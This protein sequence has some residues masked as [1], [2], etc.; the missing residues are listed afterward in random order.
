M[1]ITKK[2]WPNPGKIILQ[3]AK[4]QNSDANASHK[5]QGMFSL[6]IADIQV[7]DLWSI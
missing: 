7:W 6:K 1:F 2:V 3:M 4:L 5:V